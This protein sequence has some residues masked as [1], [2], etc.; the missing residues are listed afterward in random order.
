MRQEKFQKPSPHLAHST[1]PLRRNPRPDAATDSAS[2]AHPADGLIW[3]TQLLQSDTADRVREGTFRA[4]RGA[5]VLA[6]RVR[7][8][9][10][11]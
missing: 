3:L 7:R 11:P 9:S 2:C 10:R 5:R 4:W 8:A 6:V 1:S